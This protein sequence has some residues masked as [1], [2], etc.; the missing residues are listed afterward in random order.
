VSALPTALLLTFAREGEEE[1]IRSAREALAQVV[2]GARVAAIGTPV[3]APVLRGLGIAEVLVYG[4]ERSAGQVLAEARAWRPAAAAI[5]YRGLDPAGHLKLELLAL[6]VG[7]RRTY[8]F[9]LD[10]AMEPVGRAGLLLS[11]LGK[12]AQAWLCVCAGGLVCGSALLWLRLRQV[13]AGGH[14]ARRP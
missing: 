4:G 7:A 8:R 1:A 6:G 5:V 2:P 10:R 12:L 11:V 9:M 3:S 14:S 13:L